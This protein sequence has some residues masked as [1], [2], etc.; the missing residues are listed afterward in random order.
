MRRV[1][2]ARDRSR[3]LPDRA[4]RASLH[5]VDPGSGVIFPVCVRAIAVGI[6]QPPAE[7]IVVVKK[8]RRLGC[9]KR[10]AWEISQSDRLRVEK[11]R[12]EPENDRLIVL[13][14][15]FKNGISRVSDPISGLSTQ[16]GEMRFSRLKRGDRLK[17]RVRVCRPVAKRPAIQG[18]IQSRPFV[19]ATDV[20]IGSVGGKLRSSRAS[21]ETSPRER[22]FVSSIPSPKARPFARTHAPRPTTPSR[23]APRP[24]SA[25]AKK[26]NATFG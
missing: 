25:A 26:P 10:R 22:T 18:L 11:N 5:L 16:N 3:Y 7:K 12:P 9:A 4:G 2:P 15:R 19:T 8:N 21:S 1:Q 20:E 17:K 23:V 6:K 14:A 13:D 24:P